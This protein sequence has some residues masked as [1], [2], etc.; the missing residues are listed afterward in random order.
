MAALF[1]DDFD[2]LASEL[3]APNN[4][5]LYQWLCLLFIK[6]HLKDRDLRADRDRRNPSP[7]LSEF[8]DWEGLHHIHTVARAVQSRTVIDP[9]VQGTILVFEMGADPEPFEYGDLYDHSTI[10]IRIDRVGVVAVL[11][12]CGGAGFV[13][14]AFLSGITGPLS[15]IQLREVAARAAY[16]NELLLS[17][18]TIWTELHPNGDLFMKCD[19]PDAPRYGEVDRAALGA[20]LEYSCAP[21][22]RR[23]LTPN[24]EEIIARLA[25]GE[26]TFI[27]DNEGAFIMDSSIP[28]PTRDDA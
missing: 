6:T 21:R 12:D 14:A 8:Y 4:C 23:S 22:L 27:Y 18:P 25:R 10:F 11:N 7:Q 24:K 3:S 16:G 19:L 26:A 13:L 17:R 20:L 28:V 1:R 5:L 15:N 9:N 2:G